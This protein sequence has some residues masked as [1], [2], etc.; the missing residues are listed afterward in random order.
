MQAI[1][2]PTTRGFQSQS[3]LDVQQPA[4]PAVHI[5]KARRCHC[6]LLMPGLE[7]TGR[8]AGRG[9]VETSAAV[10]QLPRGVAG[11]GKN[12]GL[13]LCGKTAEQ[14]PGN[15][16]RGN[17]GVESRGGIAAIDRLPEGV[18]VF[19]RNA[20]LWLA[21]KAAK[22]MPG[23]RN[24]GNGRRGKP[25]GIAAIDRLPEGVAVLC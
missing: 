12:A 17:A 11:L 8:K 16:N 5:S 21:G 4:T 18:A 19:G 2:S 25:G 3:T 7:Y 20:G 6:D 1:A 23:N 22:Q 10:G 14:M 13:W 24:R 15:P 9:F